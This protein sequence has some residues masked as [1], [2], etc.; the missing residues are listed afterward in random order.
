MAMRRHYRRPPSLSITAGVL[1]AD[2]W[3]HWS[4]SAHEALCLSGTCVSCEG[5]SAIGSCQRTPAWLRPSHTGNRSGSAPRISWASEITE[6][7]QS[8]Y[9]YTSPISSINFSFLLSAVQLF[10]VV[11][12]CCLTDHVANHKAETDI[13]ALIQSMIFCDIAQ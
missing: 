12:C 11:C 6:E 2:R 3:N 5:C 4:I 7:E 13:L 8:S 9:A 10:T 1:L